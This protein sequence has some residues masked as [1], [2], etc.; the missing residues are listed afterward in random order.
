MHSLPWSSIPLPIDRQILA[1]RHMS[2]AR[3]RNTTPA[4]VHLC[5]A[6]AL[7]ANDA[8]EHCP[9]CVFAAAPLPA[10]WPRSPHGWRHVFASLLHAMAARPG[11]VPLVDRHW[12]SKAAW[13]FPGHAGALARHIAF[14]WLR[15]CSS[16]LCPGGALDN[17]HRRRGP[18]QLRCVHTVLVR[19][20]LSTGHD[21]TRALPW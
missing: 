15:E 16:H 17:A 2:A 7:W 1:A 11:H 10:S 18:S 5:V 3:W 20:G 21:M 9:A 14:S 12:D 13:P 19:W 4:Q 6:E 8:G